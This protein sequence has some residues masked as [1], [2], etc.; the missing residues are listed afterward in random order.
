MLF[1]LLL[2]FVTYCI[3]KACVYSLSFETFLFSISFF[4]NVT[5]LFISKL[6]REGDHGYQQIAKGLPGTYT[7]KD[8]RLLGRSFG[9]WAW[10]S[11]ISL[12]WPC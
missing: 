8:E 12:T 10:K 9:V 11:G 4:W 1:D 6:F 7:Q 5:S 2:D 3:N